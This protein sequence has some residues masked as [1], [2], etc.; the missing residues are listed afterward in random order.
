[1]QGVR[2]AAK[3]LAPRFGFNLYPLDSPAVNSYFMVTIDCWELLW[4]Q[5]GNTDRPSAAGL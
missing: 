4:R 5:Y 3:G 2:G 1:M